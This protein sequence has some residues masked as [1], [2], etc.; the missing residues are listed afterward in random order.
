MCVLHSQFF[1]PNIIA[2]STRS[3]PKCEFRKFSKK[4]AGLPQIASEWMD[5]EVSREVSIL[6]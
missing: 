4:L 5:F 6:E 2:A 1:N 3:T